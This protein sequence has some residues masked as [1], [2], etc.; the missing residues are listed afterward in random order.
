M[1][2]IYKVGKA[3]YEVTIW[4][5]DLAMQ[6]K[7][8]IYNQLEDCRYTPKEGQV[9]IE[10]TAGEMWCAPIDKVCRTYTDMDGQPLTPETFEGLDA[11]MSVKTRVA[12]MENWA[13]QVPAGETM[14]VETSWG[15]TLTA[16]RS[17]IPHGTG[18][19]IVMASLPNGEPD[20]NDRWV[21]NGEIFDK[22]Y[23]VDREQVLM[24]DTEKNVGLLES[25][26]GVKV[27]ILDEETKQLETISEAGAED[28]AEFIRDFKESMENDHDNAAAADSDKGIS[29]D[30]D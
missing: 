24:L 23:N 7:G 20:F 26:D 17:G 28:K 4:P 22:T 30:D 15:E 6:E 18:D 3:E 8:E 21:V 1:Q 14:M 25:P 10:G 13:F 27:V 16:N 12:E 9:V 29:L 19:Y 11:P 2:N 5:A